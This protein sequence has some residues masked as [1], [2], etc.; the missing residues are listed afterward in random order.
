MFN[1]GN[2]QTSKMNKGEKKINRI[3]IRKKKK[4]QKIKGI[5]K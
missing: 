1:S 5:S 4:K 2:Q 3:Q